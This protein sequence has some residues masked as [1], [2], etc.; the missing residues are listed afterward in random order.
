MCSLRQYEASDIAIGRHFVVPTKISCS[1][2]D[3]SIIRVHLEALDRLATNIEQREDRTVA[4]RLDPTT[5]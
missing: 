3:G 1:R 2:F 5:R 4:S